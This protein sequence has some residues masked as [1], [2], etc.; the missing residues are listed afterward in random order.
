M[1]PGREPR[2]PGP[3]FSICLFF[4]G[5]LLVVGCQSVEPRARVPQIRVDTISVKN[6]SYFEQRFELE[7]SVENPNEFELEIA[8]I[9]YR[10]FVNS[11]EFG[12]GALSRLISIPAKTAI[13]IRLKL[14]SDLRTV[15]EHL[16]ESLERKGTD[17]RLKGFLSLLKFGR[18]AFD[19]G[20]HAVPRENIPSWKA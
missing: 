8:A 1:L 15:F 10:L 12:S 19:A 16:S 17:F 6:F 18:H 4:A 14:S 13:P 3:R 20:R 7:V 5:L 9:E 11:H 2:R